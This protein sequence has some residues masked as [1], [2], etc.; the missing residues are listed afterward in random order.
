MVAALILPL[1]DVGNKDMDVYEKRYHQ[2]AHQDAIHEVGVLLELVTQIN[3]C[4]RVCS[5][6]TPRKLED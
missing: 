6:H 5:V 1:S 2:H 4:C 3:G